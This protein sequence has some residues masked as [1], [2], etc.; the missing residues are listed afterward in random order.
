[1]GDGLAA[2][3]RAAA[4]SQLDLCALDA[5]TGEMC[6]LR[7]ASVQL[8]AAAVAR[9]QSIVAPLHY[10]QEPVV[11][12]QLVGRKRVLLFPPRTYGSLQP[13]PSSHPL[14][15]RARR[16][17]SGRVRAADAEA[18]GGVEVLL[19]AGEALLL[20]PYTWHEVSTVGA[21]EGG[22][23][24]MATATT[25]TRGGGGGG[26][27]RGGGREANVS[28]SVRLASRS[29]TPRDH[30]MA[31]AAGGGASDPASGSGASATAAGGPLTG[32]GRRGIRD[33]R[34]TLVP[35][36]MRAEPCALWV[37]VSRHVEWLITE[38]IDASGSLAA[39][40][41]VGRA[42]AS[43]ACAQTLLDLARGMH[44]ASRC[45]CGLPAPPL[46]RGWPPPCC[47]SCCCSSSASPAA[48]R[49]GVAAAAALVQSLLPMLLRLVAGR[50]CGLVA[51]LRRLPICWVAG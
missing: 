2:L 31:A 41:D 40:D 5:C 35:T 22:A 4:W 13:Y 16:D 9:T 25:T 49:T 47:S 34:T 6:H 45:A 1:M 20:P 18:L 15:R 17:V 12:M 39:H 46:C 32:E 7:P 42:A 11:I 19:E 27:T 8:F 51:F 29:C 26:G 24:E 3:L 21:P 33:V 30:P 48:V 23:R 37:G 43:M 44:A 36:L 50:P 28:F 10:D 38:R 14:D